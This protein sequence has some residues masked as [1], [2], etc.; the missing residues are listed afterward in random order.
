MAPPARVLTSLLSGPRLVSDSFAGGG[1]GAVALA[2]IDAESPPK[3]SFVVE[4][5][6]V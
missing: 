5:A 2:F 3:T 4:P 1:K 6:D